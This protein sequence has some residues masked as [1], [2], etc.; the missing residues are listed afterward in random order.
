M[1][2]FGIIGLGPPDD[3]RRVD[4]RADQPDRHVL[5]LRSI[6]WWEDGS[7]GRGTVEL[8]RV[9]LTTSARRRRSLVETGL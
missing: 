4:L 6:L 5:R 3:P 1:F 7:L 8:F 2:D 9:K